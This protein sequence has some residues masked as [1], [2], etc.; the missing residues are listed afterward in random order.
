V[1]AEYA[2]TV[3]LCKEGMPAPTYWTRDDWR[4]AVMIA[5][6]MERLA[7]EELPRKEI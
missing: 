1:V 4:N 3:A 6:R 7:H 2:E 5:N